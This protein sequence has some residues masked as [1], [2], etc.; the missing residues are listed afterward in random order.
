[1][2]INHGQR[3]KLFKL[4]GFGEEIKIKT[5]PKRKYKLYSLRDFY[6]Y[7]NGQITSKATTAWLP[8]NITSK[9]IVDT[10][11]L[12]APINYQ[13]NESAINELPQKITEHNNKEFLLN[14]KMRYTDIDLNQHVNN[15]KYIELIMDS[16]PKEQYEKSVLKSIAVNFV[17][18]CKYNDELEIYKSKEILQGSD[19][20]EGINKNSSKLVFQANLKWSLQ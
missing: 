5:W 4:P 12:P 16:F 3:L 7:N 15:I 18:E 14:R 1:M 11:G 6:I 19:I 13:E 17:S 2:G 9:R 10:S 20:I 8:I